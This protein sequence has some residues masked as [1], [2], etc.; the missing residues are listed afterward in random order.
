MNSPASDAD[1]LRRYAATGAP[2]DLTGLVQRYV[3]LVYSAA[4][5]Q[6]C[7]SHAAQDVTQQVFIVLLRKGRQL[8]PETVVASWLL[9]V[10]ALECRNVIKAEARRARRERKVAQMRS[11]VGA[12]R[13][14]GESDHSSMAPGWEE[15]SPHLDAALEE[16][17][18]G[19]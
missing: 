2:D 6:L 11:E 8:R 5:R 3:D 12:E 16:L 14:G 18:A 1:L 7:D 13:A 9:K 17:S 19:D 10:T 4:R 15:L